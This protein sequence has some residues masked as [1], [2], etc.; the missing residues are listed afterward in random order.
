MFGKCARLMTG[1]SIRNQKWKKQQT[2]TTHGILLLRS[3]YDGPVRK[4]PP[5]PHLKTQYNNRFEKIVPVIIANQEAW[6]RKPPGG[7][8]GDNV[9]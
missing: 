7:R 3:R 2:K 4:A 5:H 9:I 6:Q 8:S 1:R